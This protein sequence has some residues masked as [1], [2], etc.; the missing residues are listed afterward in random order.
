[1][2]K[3]F[4]AVI[5]LALLACI[6]A[7]ASAQRKTDV[8]KM[9]NGDRVTGEIKTLTA[10]ILSFST[11]SMGTIKIEWQDIA[12]LQSK[13]NYEIRLS[14][15]ERVFGSMGEPER[16]GQLLIS[17]LGEDLA[18]EWLEVVE[19]RP[20]EDHWTER[21]DV[22]LSGTY[23]YTKA[24]SVATTQLNTELSYSDEDALNSL[25]AR[26]TH[27]R[28]GDE[29]SRSSRSNFTRS[30]WSPRSRN[31]R[32]F[33]GSY[34]SNDELG[35]QHRYAGG[36]GLGRFILDSHRMRWTGV[37][38][39][40]ALTEQ[41]DGGTEEQS[42]EGVLTSDFRTWRLDTPE[43]DISWVINLYPNLSEIGRTR[44]DTDLRVRWEIVK[45]LFWDITAWGTYDSDAETENQID[46]G[47][48]TGV[49][50]KY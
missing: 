2:K 4:L 5:M 25:T 31:F 48:S 50:W 32:S 28:T 35:L 3:P 17:A 37:M 33:W 26:N 19:L 34:E 18:L 16:A 9:F 49:G 8:V 39:L 44:G 40:Q 15:G 38:G 43:L 24:S 21:L 12:S 23:S 22:Y 45:D 6:S 14:S 20:I 1:M 30:V 42:V 36:A 41:S 13:Y 7:N 46:Y 27:T 47:I 29:V 10:G 11:D